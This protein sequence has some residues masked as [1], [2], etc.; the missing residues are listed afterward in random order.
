MTDQLSIDF[1]AP[2]ARRTD[3]ETSHGA[4][5]IAIGDA[6]NNR[7]LALLALLAAGPDG[8]N[9]FELA[10]EVSRRLGRPVK[11]TSAGV[12]RHELVQLGLVEA[13]VVAD[14]EQPLRVRKVT[15]PSDTGSPSIVWV[16]TSAA[17]EYVAENAAGAA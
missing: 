12:R 13:L 9:D 6:R 15:R 2:T 17:G 10:A 3:P 4:A 8:L 1:A 16:A 14:P 7:A 11:Q 5:V